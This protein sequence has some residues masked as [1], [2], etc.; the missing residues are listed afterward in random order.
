MADLK[1]DSVSV[2]AGRD[3]LQRNPCTLSDIIDRGTTVRSRSARSSREQL[4]SVRIRSGGAVGVRLS[5]TGVPHPHLRFLLA[6]P[7]I[8]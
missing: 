2:S 7:P 4:A 5:I 3:A 6:A 1:V 8:L